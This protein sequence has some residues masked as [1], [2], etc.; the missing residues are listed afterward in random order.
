MTFSLFWGHIAFAFYSKRRNIPWNLPLKYFVFSTSSY[1]HEQPQHGRVFMGIHSYT[2]QIQLLL[3]HSAT[4]ARQSVRQIPPS[5]TCSLCCL[6]ISPT[7]S[8][9]PENRAWIIQRGKRWHLREAGWGHTTWICS[10]TKTNSSSP[11]SW[12]REACPRSAASALLNAEQ[13][14]LSSKAWQAQRQ[15]IFICETL[16]SPLP[17]KKTLTFLWLILRHSIH[18][19]GLPAL[20]GIHLKQCS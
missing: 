1:R 3:L 13:H 12:L 11:S 14:L 9:F 20:R 7:N 15:N 17:I 16:S 4:P 6:Q 5:P 10:I 19:Q 2:Y 18:P 8:A